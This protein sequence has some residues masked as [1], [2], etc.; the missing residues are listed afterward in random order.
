MTPRR[1]SLML[2]VGC[3]GAGI[4]AV[5]ASVAVALDGSPIGYVLAPVSTIG[6]GVSVW[7]WRRWGRHLPDV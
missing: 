4:V 2:A 6:L 7:T 5:G 3:V 1:T